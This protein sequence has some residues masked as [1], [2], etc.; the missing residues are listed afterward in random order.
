M[1]TLSPS[2]LLWK[3]MSNKTLEVGVEW[4]QEVVQKIIVNFKKIKDKDQFFIY[5]YNT[6]VST[7]FCVWYA[8]IQ[9][10][11]W[12]SALLPYMVMVFGSIIKL[13]KNRLF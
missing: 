5:I 1:Q 2:L 13:T 11:R 7:S 9:W 6:S 10:F 12:H 4:T 8:C 3:R